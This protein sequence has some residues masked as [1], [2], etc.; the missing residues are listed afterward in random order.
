[1]NNLRAIVA[2]W[3]NASQRRRV[4]VGLNGFAGNQMQS[5]LSGPTE[6]LRAS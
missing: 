6:S 2:A 1:M 3:L 4:G 5:A